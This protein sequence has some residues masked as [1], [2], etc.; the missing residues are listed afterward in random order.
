[1]WPPYLKSP[2][3]KSQLSAGIVK[4][5]GWGLLGEYPL[6]PARRRLAVG[7]IVLI[8]SSFPRQYDETKTL[9]KSHPQ[10]CAIGDDEE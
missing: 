10:I 1:M 2:G 7:F 8:S 9:L 6:R 4:W 5:Y 3:I